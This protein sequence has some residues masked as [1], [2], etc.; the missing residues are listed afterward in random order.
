MTNKGL[1]RTQRLSTSCP[2]PACAC[3]KNPIAQKECFQ[4]HQPSLLS[5]WKEPS[6]EHFRCTDA[7]H[8]T[9]ACEIETAAHGGAKHSS[10]SSIE[11]TLLN[12]RSTANCSNH[13]RKR[14]LLYAYPLLLGCGLGKDPGRA[15]RA[16]LRAAA[17]LCSSHKKVFVLTNEFLGHGAFSLRH[18]A[19]QPVQHQGSLAPHLGLDV[20][21]LHV[22]WVGKGVK[23]KKKDKTK[24]GEKGEKKKKRKK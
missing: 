8:S 19:R 11:Q 14:L 10:S 20:P 9:G 23:K 16:S 17:H 2:H 3:S 12:L 22:G 7:E 15:Q 21:C 18:V 13:A 1:T 24:M 4:Q 5:C 6:R